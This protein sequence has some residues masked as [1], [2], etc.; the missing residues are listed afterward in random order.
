[1][2]NIDLLI[3]ETPIAIL[4][5]GKG[6]LTENSK[7]IPKGAYIIKDF[8]LAFY[9]LKSYI[10]AGFSHF[11]LA[12][13]D[14]FTE[15]KDKILT[16][17]KNIRLESDDSYYLE[18]FSKEIKINFVE[19]GSNSSTGE[20]LFK[21]LEI[22]PQSKYLGLTYSDS[23]SDLNVKDYFKWYIN[24]NA[25][26]SL[27]AVKAPIRF[28]ILGLTPSDPIV[29][30]FSDKAFIHSHLINGGFYFFDSSFLKQI[31]FHNS[32]LETDIL[33]SIVK[34]KKLF[35]YTYTGYWQCLDSERDVNALNDIASHLMASLL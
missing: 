33:E 22:M 16:K 5:G 9:V 19:T 21:L 20:R 34:D 32:T 18:V 12:G 25:P 23:I 15:L 13:G 11:Y 3:K 8:P 35:A 2:E 17:A 30:G 26:C 6:I 24:H 28:R 31:L 10:D 29:K 4:C 14:N 7:K 1:M 27:I